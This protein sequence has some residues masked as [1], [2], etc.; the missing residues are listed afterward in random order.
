L[1][2]EVNVGVRTPDQDESGSRSVDFDVYRH[3]A[4]GYD[5]L[6]SSYDREIGS[7]PIG[8]RMHAVLTE[9]LRRTFSEGQSVFEIGCGTGIDALSLARAG[10]NIVATD[11]SQEMVELVKK[12]AK[13][14][15]LTDRIRVNR[16]RASEI[17]LLVEDYGQ[18]S[19]DGGFCHAGA[20]NMEPA[21]ER[22]PPQL[23]RLIRRGGAFVCS[24]INKTS[25]FEL[26]FYPLVLRPRK[27]FRRLGN[28]V[29]IPISRE[30]P[31]NQYVVPSQFYSPAE[32]ARLFR[33]DFALE[34]L[35]GLQI[36]LPPANLAEYYAAIRPAFAPFE[37]LE[38]TLSRLP[39]FNTWGHHSILTLRRS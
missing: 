20:L 25:L 12:K 9:V 13:T 22:V 31:L 35:Q 36:F 1:H 39:P 19:F 29:P 2:E 18:E 4:Q 5:T 26:L 17:A 14:E 11:I 24:I 28:T 7:N 21:L 37:I 34:S 38:K 8:K 32:V 15:G 23:C 6:A 10:F 33:P 27:A 16:L 30:P 3:I